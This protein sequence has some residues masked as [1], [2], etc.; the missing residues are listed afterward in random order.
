MRQVDALEQITSLMNCV[1]LLAN[2][3]TV[4]ISGR[5]RGV[6]RWREDIV[7]VGDTI[8]GG[9]GIQ[10]NVICRTLMEHLLI[11]VNIFCGQ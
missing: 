8:V 6:L 4:G 10:L 11:L 1:F 5:G 3:D 7:R 2:G 9:A